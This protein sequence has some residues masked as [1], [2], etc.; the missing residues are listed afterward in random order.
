MA[1]VFARAL[2]ARTAGLSTLNRTLLITIENAFS[3]VLEI[4]DLNLLI[5]AS[6]TDSRFNHQSLL[7][8]RI[9]KTN[10]L[11]AILKVPEF[12]E[13]NYGTNGGPQPGLGEGFYSKEDEFFVRLI[14]IAKG[15]KMLTR[16]IP[17]LFPYQ[18]LSMIVVI[19]RNLHVIVHFPT[20]EESDIRLRSLFRMVLIALNGMQFGSFL[21]CFEVLINNNS[22]VPYLQRRLVKTVKT[23][24]GMAIF[25]TFLQKAYDV[26]V[27][28]V[29]QYRQLQNQNIPPQLLGQQQSHFEEIQKLFNFWQ[30]LYVLLFEQLQGKL[31]SLF[32]SAVV[33]PQT[34]TQS[35]QN[36]DS[37]YEP[38]TMA[39]GYS[40]G[41]VSDSVW[42][43]FVL[44][45]KNANPYQ[46]HIILQELSPII[47]SVEHTTTIK[48]L[49]QVLGQII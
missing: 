17:I 26:S 4:E 7:E 3:D 14:S 43:F 10:H 5:N 48:V 31:S 25:S 24:I 21:I 49:L 22:G 8:K 27:N 47:S 16:A 29:S 18:V 39:A 34:L 36:R 44:L 20:N 45:A 30:R 15:A 2:M 40:N 38:F 12:T 6:S 19:L 11:Y 9:E 23:K 42:H 37:E 35:S 33:L 28:L 46:K 41:A 1:A 13:G 32:N